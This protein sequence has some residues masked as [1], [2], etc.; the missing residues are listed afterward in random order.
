LS[1]I[2][3]KVIIKNKF[4]LG[5]LLAKKKITQKITTHLQLKISNICVKKSG[6]KMLEQKKRF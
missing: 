1:K 4:Y 2:V 5:N 6:Q 3:E